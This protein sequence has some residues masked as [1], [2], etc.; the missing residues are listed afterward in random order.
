LTYFL[1]FQGTLLCAVL[2]SGV[3]TLTQRPID[4]IGNGAAP[5]GVDLPA[6]Q[7]RPSFDH[8]LNH[9]P[10]ALAR[11]VAL[12]PFGPVELG[13]AHDRRCVTLSLQGQFLAAYADGRIVP[14]ANLE[15]WQ[16][17]LPIAQ[18]EL[19]T[20]RQ[21]L[22]ND[23]VI[24]S[25]GALVHAG[26]IALENW[27]TLRVGG[28]KLDLRYQLPFDA[29]EWPFRLT[30]LNEGWRIEQLCLYRPLI[31]FTAFGNPTAIAQ[32][33]ASV[34]S[35]I[36]IGRYSGDL[37]VLTDQAP[38]A[39][40]ANLPP[41]AP[42]RLRTHP[43][44]PSDFIGFVASRYRILEIPWAAQFQPV[45]YMDTDVVFDAGV[46]PMLRAVACAD[47]I[48]AP[49]EPFSPLRTTPSVGSGLLELDACTPGFAVG[50]NGGTMGIPNIP[51]HAATL[52]LI[53]TIMVNHAA[54]NGRAAFAWVDQ[55][56]ANYVS[57]RLAHFCRAIDPFVR[58][59]GWEDT[60][61]STDGRVGLVH[62]WP[63]LGADKK[64]AAMQR[65]RRRIDTVLAAL[66]KR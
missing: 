37:L 21:I 43:A 30:V 15:D 50:F 46:E 58:Y 40:V 53:R 26:D 52:R 12:D 27:Y 9:T 45:M 24:R 3:V 59:G 11:V 31:Y 6:E 16:G 64:F 48:A 13:R 8:F 29:A 39:I 1:T 60:E 28:L 62:F 54:I 14:D 57:F 5:V 51:A 38:D 47:R 19:E 49:L 33:L 7:L 63:A 65:Y 32:F 34:R 25:S 41:M 17:F 18:P 36:E 42:G 56:V 61:P 66:G 2:E 35:L 20:L 22:R 23:W 10:P 55:E 44:A 4:A